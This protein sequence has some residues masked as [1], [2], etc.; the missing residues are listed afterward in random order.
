V[1]ILIDSNL[2][3][4]VFERRQPHYA[5]S[6]QILKLA[7]RGTVV[8]HVSSHTLANLFYLFGKSCVPFI[9]ESMLPHIEVTAGDAHQTQ[10]ALRAGM[11]DFEDAL[12]V[13]AALQCRAAFIVTRN[14]RD[15][16]R[17]PIPALTPVEWIK[18]FGPGLKS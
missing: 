9:R 3:F 1:R 13:A 15:F 5:A 6:N 17:S 12:Q 7:R 8:G 11:S 10:V 2:V 18:R 16:K 4:D 14:V